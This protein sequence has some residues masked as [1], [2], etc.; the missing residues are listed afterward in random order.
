MAISTIH[1]LCL[2]SFL[3]SVAVV[4]AAAPP[5]EIRT[6]FATHDR[7]IHVKDGW[8]RDPYI[9]RGSD[10]WFYLTGTTQMPEQ[11]ETPEA[12]YNTGLGDGSLV[13]WQARVWRTRDFA[14]WEDLG[15]PFTLKDGIWFKA[16]PKRFEEVPQ[17][18]WR[19]WAPELHEVG[20]RWALVHTSPSPVNGAN[21]ALSKGPEIKGPWSHPMGETI[22]KRHDPSL[23]RD[24]DG[25]WWL[26][27]GA[28][29]I[30]PLKN[31]FS[32]GAE[33]PTTIGPSGETA[34]M[35]HE[36]C[37]LRKIGGK[38][39]LF[40]TGWS[41]GEMRKGSYNLYY[42]TAEDIKGP[43]TERKF[44]GRFL[45]HGTPFQDDRGRWWCTAFYNANIPPL[46]REG[47]E[48]KDLSE[49]AQTINEQGVTLVP[50]EVQ[51]AD[52]EI[53]IR[54]IDPAYA[55][56]GP[57]ELQQFSLSADR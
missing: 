39:V 16:R 46:P 43:Y 44:V 22:G 1:R 42:A 37:L 8:I 25:T 12:K 18:Q 38:Y 23:F 11:E 49:N 55:T 34:K 2:A 27:W 57:D 21:L 45:G 40:G 20:G 50:L 30:A 13:G 54:A 51:T 6:A 41:T 4:H 14:V 10:G 53:M 48:K 33:P 32:D 36:G 17:A 26:I 7:A 5:D 35:G 19:L 28:T 52:S 15:S 9:V 24:D 47:I 29:Q 3:S 56:P 31:D